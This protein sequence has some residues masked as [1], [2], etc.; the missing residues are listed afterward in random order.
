MTVSRVGSGTADDQ[1]PSAA[2]PLARAEMPVKP[3]AAAP[4]W[5][6]VID[7]MAAQKRSLTVEGATEGGSVGKT[8]S[9]S[10]AAS[11]KPSPRKP[12]ALPVPLIAPICLDR[13]FR[14][15]VR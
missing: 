1:L 13:A 2:P 4:S 9:R 11:A 8:K 14:R 5:Q 15:A 7:L 10:S 6:N 12:V 3:E